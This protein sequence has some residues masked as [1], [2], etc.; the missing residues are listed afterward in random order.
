[1]KAPNCVSPPASLIH[2]VS[3]GSLNPSTGVT[4][5]TKYAG[6]KTGMFR[7]PMTLKF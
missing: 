6:V 3:F 4:S 2:S 5:E 7:R 1:M